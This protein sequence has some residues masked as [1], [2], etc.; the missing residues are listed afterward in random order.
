MTLS[1]DNSSAW[2]QE[3]LERF[4]I[5]SLAG[6]GQGFDRDQQQEHWVEYLQR[7]GVEHALANHGL[8]EADQ[9]PERFEE[10]MDAIESI[11]AQ[12][13]RDVPGGSRAVVSEAQVFLLFYLAALVHGKVLS[14]AEAHKLSHDCWS[15]CSNHE[16]SEDDPTAFDVADAEADAP[17]P[18]TIK[19]PESPDAWV[20]ELSAAY[21]KTAL[22][23]PLVLDA[24]TF[25]AAPK[26]LLE[27]AV[28]LALTYRGIV[29]P[30]HE[31]RVLIDA[32]VDMEADVKRRGPEWAQMQA[33]QPLAFIMYYLWV[34]LAI[35]CIEEDHAGQIVAACTAHLD[36]FPDPDPESESKP[37]TKTKPKPKKVQPGKRSSS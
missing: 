12:L 9:A 4:G 18:V 35:G 17:W 33:I 32:I 31:V 22:V 20:A 15:G 1:P 2:L 6:A 3:V 36:A 13:H 7:Q 29:V 27:A 19:P 10:T 37:K 26:S 11:A 5:A 34:H 25:Q 28:V 23:P 30:L 24:G 8:R 16:N 14:I 21:E